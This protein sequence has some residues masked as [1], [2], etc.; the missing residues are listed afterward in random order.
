MLRL[1]V[2][3]NNFSAMSGRNQRFLGLTS[4]VGSYCVLL[5]TAT[6]VGIDNVPVNNFSA[7][8]GRNQRFLGLTSTVGSYC[9]LLNT[10]TPVGIE[11]RTSRFGVRCSTTTPPRSLTILNFEMTEWCCSDISGARSTNMQDSRTIFK[12][13][14]YIKLCSQPVCAAHHFVGFQIAGLGI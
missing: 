7:K 4:T 5:N 8:S 1:N 14:S 9:V 2:P 11:P 10:A 3:V 13:P 12:T 6:P